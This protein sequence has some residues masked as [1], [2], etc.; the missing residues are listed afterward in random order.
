METYDEEEAA[1]ARHGDG[2]DDNSLLPQALSSADDVHG[3]RNKQNGSYTCAMGSGEKEPSFA[4]RMYSRAPSSSV[5]P[6]QLDLTR[7]AS[8]EVSTS[9]SSFFVKILYC[10]GPNTTASAHFRDKL[11][12]GFRSAVAVCL[13]T[14]LSY[15]WSWSSQS[16]F[17]TI[18]FSVTTLRRNLGETLFSILDLWH[19]AILSI[20]FIVFCSFFRQS[21]VCMYIMSLLLFCY[22]L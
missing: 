7:H 3:S 13:S 6:S 11:Q 2:G 9:P 1:A 5:I 8:E 12:M 22:S 17:L 21:K 19:A 16:T 15:L 14:S 18:I 10:Q 4:P 20:P